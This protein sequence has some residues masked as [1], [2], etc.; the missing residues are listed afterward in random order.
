MKKI[1]HIK[2]IQYQKMQLRV[3]QLELERKISNDWKDLK[4]NLNPKIFLKN[5]S[6]GNLDNHDEKPTL[7]SNILGYGA[8]YLSNRL[9]EITGSKI[10]SAMQ[11]GADVLAKKLNKVFQKRP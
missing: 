11:K 4:E 1:K 3:K 2:D 5:K 8:G 9:S 10:E 6:L 7:F